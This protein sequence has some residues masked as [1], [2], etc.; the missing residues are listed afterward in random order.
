MNIWEKMQVVRTELNQMDLKR[1]GY[2]KNSNY[3][4]F[5]LKD[6]LPQTMEL[7]KEHKIGSKF[8][9]TTKYIQEVEIW[10]EVATLIIINTEE[11]SDVIVYETP[12]AEVM[13]GAYRNKETQQLMGGAQPIQ[14]L[15]GKHSYLKRYLYQN[16]LELV[17]ADVVDRSTEVHEIYTG[18]NISIREAKNII[19]KNYKNIYKL[20]GTRVVDVNDLFKE[21]T[22]GGRLKD[23]SIS[24]LLK[25]EKELA[26]SNFKEHRFFQRLYG[27]NSKAT[28]TVEADTQIKYQTSLC[29][30]A[31]LAYEMATEDIKDEVLGFY[32]QN[33]IDIVEYLEVE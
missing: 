7:F 4:Y 30:F 16:A 5:E 3:P 13:I 26:K 1:S 18:I 22:Y 11:T 19:G 31:V 14:N 28:D 23:A 32:Q 20:L 15:G 6:F 21:T 24:Q 33:G 29:K 9:I 17:D 10:R 25:F 27:T 8:D 2:N 12:T